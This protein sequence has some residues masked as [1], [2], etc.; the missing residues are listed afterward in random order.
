MRMVFAE[1]SGGG[2]WCFS[3]WRS[4]SSMDQMAITRTRLPVTDQP[5]Q[6]KVQVWN[7]HALGTLN[8]EAVQ[9]Q[10]QAAH[11]YRIYQRRNA[12]HTP[13]KSAGVARSLYVVSGSCQVTNESSGQSCTVRSGE[14]LQMPEGRYTLSY[15]EATEVI[16][17]VELPPEAWQFTFF[18]VEP[19]P[20][21]PF[22]QVAANLWGD[23]P[24]DSDGN[25][26]SP[27]DSSWTELT[28]ALR[29]DCKQRVDI[30]PACE[31]P[32]VLKIVSSSLPLAEQA[33][34]FLALRTQGRFAQRWPTA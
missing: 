20:R 33:A 18:V 19:G 9:T 4:F 13:F 27:G 30:D 14:F 22:G 1:A 10:H 3:C 16:W 12:P 7:V 25:S 8:L 26:E 23:A 2:I 29:P 24:F 31:S 21:P 11:K 17:A 6:N 5:D 15:P 32:L 34:R 28:I